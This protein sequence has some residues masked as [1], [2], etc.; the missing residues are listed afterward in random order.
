MLESLETKNYFTDINTVVVLTGRR[1]IQ[2][3]KMQTDGYSGKRLR[4]TGLETG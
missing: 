3:G 4:E 2:P 1:T